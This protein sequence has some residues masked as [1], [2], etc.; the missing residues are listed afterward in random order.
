VNQSRA[1]VEI[2]ALREVTADNEAAVRAL[3]VEPRQE[4][5]VAAVSESLDEAASSPDAHPWYRAIYAGD[6]PVGFV[7]LSFD[8]PPGRLEYPCGTSCGVCSST[9]DTSGAGTA[10]PQWRS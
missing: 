6:R 7:M 2:V 1:D 10:A 4:S 9:P 8:V 5:F 3:A